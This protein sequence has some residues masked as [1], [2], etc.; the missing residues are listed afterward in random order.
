MDPRITLASG[1]HLAGTPGVWSWGAV[2]SAFPSTPSTADPGC[3]M[4]ITLFFCFLSL[5]SGIPGSKWACYVILLYIFL[6]KTISLYTCITQIQSF[7]E[8]QWGEVL[9]ARHF[10]VLGTKLW[11]KQSLLSVCLI[12]VGCSIC[13]LKNRVIFHVVI[14]YNKVFNSTQVIRCLGFSHYKKMLQG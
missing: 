12:L 4:D 14:S 9:F 3:L 5:D 13:P 6:A 2:H 10:W 7:C 8:V 1:I 11:V